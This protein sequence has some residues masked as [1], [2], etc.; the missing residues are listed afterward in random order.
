MSEEILEYS[1]SIGV[2]GNGTLEVFVRW[3]ESTCALV[4]ENFSWEE[5]GGLS[6]LSLGSYEIEVTYKGHTVGIVSCDDPSECKKVMKIF[7]KVKERIRLGW[8]IPI[9]FNKFDFEFE[10]STPC[11]AQCCPPEE[12]ERVPI[13][14]DTNTVEK[15]AARWERRAKHQMAEIGIK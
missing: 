7:I 12:E 9:R 6:V 2:L 1:T 13:T 4:Y 14:T 10:V 8:V 3:D 5:G 15:P 11:L